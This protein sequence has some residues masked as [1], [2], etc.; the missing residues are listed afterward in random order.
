[1]KY[2]VG[3]I[4]VIKTDLLVE[5]FYGGFSWQSTMAMDNNIA[6]IED[7]FKDYYSFEGSDYFYTDEMIDHTSTEL[8]SEPAKHNL[9]KGQGEITYNGETFTPKDENDMKADDGKLRYDLVPPF[10]EKALAQ[11]MTPGASKY[12]PD[13]WKHLDDGERRYLAAFKR[14]F[15]DFLEG[16][17]HDIGKGGQGY[18]HLK[19]CLFNIMALLY[20]HE[21]RDH[22][23]DV[24]KP[25][26]GK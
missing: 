14:H 4:V 3:Q 8:L 23:S 2:K 20:F 7:V 15:T 18:H 6:R 9:L 10:V 5:E 13:S 16:K 1:M 22:G 24:R 11:V 25:V 19:N 12:G 21:I 26:E 17:T